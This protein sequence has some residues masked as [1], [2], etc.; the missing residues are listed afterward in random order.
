MASDSAVPSDNSNPDQENSNTGG[1]TGK[2]ENAPEVT[3]KLVSNYRH[4]FNRIFF[5]QTLSL[6]IISQLKILM[7]YSKT[8][9]AYM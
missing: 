2:Q 3:E 9:D 8:I 7:H 6:L 5:T 1:Q 4:S